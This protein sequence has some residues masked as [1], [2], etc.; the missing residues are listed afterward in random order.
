MNTSAAKD[1]L[2]VLARDVRVLTTRQIARY[3]FRGHCRPLQ[4]ADRVVRR[5]VND[6]LVETSRAMIT[7][8]D[9]TQPIYVSPA[10]D[11][12]APNFEKLA[13]QNQKR[14]RKPL[15]QATL[16]VITPLGAAHYGGYARGPRRYEREH[17]IAL[18]ECY[19]QLWEAIPHVAESWIAEEAIDARRFENKRPD[20]ILSD[21]GETILE[22]LGRGYNANKIERLFEHFRQYTIQFR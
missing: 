10:G 9:V 21:N 18:S 19:L 8:V 20:A 13:W 7:V 16:V 5:L 6:A 17:D 4:A 11:T 15:Q 2:Q 22:V 14:W 12:T 3:W 1:I